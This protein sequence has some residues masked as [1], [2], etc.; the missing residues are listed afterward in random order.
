M[1]RLTQCSNRKRG[2]TREWTAWYDVGQLCKLEVMRWNI[3]GYYYCCC[4][5]SSNTGA[6][7]TVPTRRI[8]LRCPDLENQVLAERAFFLAVLVLMRALFFS[9]F[10]I[11]S[12]LYHE[13]VQPHLLSIWNCSPK[14]SSAAGASWPWLTRCLASSLTTSTCSSGVRPVM[15]VSMTEP[16]EAL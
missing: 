2:V 10:L 3:G 16:G 9:S 14:Y 13:K 12:I 7:S 15:A 1:R 6:Y 5:C 8:I 11:L 4:C